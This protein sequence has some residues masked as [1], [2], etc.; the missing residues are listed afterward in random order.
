MSSIIIDQGPVYEWIKRN[1]FSEHQ[2]VWIY[3]C[4]SSWNTKKIRFVCR[5]RV[6]T[7]QVYVSHIVTWIT[8]CA[9]VLLEAPTVVHI[10]PMSK[11]VLEDVGPQDARV[12]SI[13]DADWIIFN[14]LS[15]VDNSR[16][17]FLARLSGQ[18]GQLATQLSVKNHPLRH[19][20]KNW[21]PFVSQG[22]V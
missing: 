16:R 18:P 3:N 1:L 6:K 4:A 15:S 19:V 8:S 12:F 9:H 20:E 7:D 11:S 10:T 13:G 5:V 14:M 17:M 22:K 21:T 2:N